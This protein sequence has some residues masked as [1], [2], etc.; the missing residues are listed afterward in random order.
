VSGRGEVWAHTVNH[1]P[2]FPAMPPPYVVAIVELVEEPGLRLTTN[3]VGCPP[4][5]VRAGMG[6]EVGFEDVGGGVWLPLFRPV[7]P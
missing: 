6:V 7:D 5:D 1:Q 4:D 2:W 3:I